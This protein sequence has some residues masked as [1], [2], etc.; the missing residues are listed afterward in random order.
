MS[1]INID[2]I[3]EDLK[4]TI[5]KEKPISHELET[6]FLEYAMSVIV[7]RALPD[8]KDGFKPVHR[9][10]LYAA[11]GLGMTSD[12]PYKKSARLVG[13]VIGKYHPHGDT[14]VYEAMVRLAQ[15]F[16]MRYPLIDGHGNF[17]SVDGDSP[18]AMRYTEARM[19]KLADTMLDDIDKDTV[20]FVD[21]YD[22]SEKEPV[23]LP[24]L[25]PNMLGNG[26]SGIAVGM[27][28]NIPPHN[29]NE[30]VAAIKLIANNHEVTIE[31][32]EQVLKGP[33]FPTAAEIIGV[34]G[35]HDYFHTGRGSI[36]IRAK[37]EY[38]THENGKSTI[39]FKEI[40]YMVNKAD[41][42]SRIVDLVKNEHIEG[43][44]DLKDESSR[45]GIR[46]VIETK[47]DVVPEVLMNQLYKNT[48]LQVNFSV[49]MLA[50]VDGEPKLLNIKQALEVYLEHQIHVL[51]RKTRFDLKKAQEREHILQ[52][53]HIATNNI[54]AIIKIIR[55][56]DDTPTAQNILMQQF[57]LSEIQSKAI[58]DMRLKTLSSIER[59]RIEEELKQLA[60]KITELNNILGDEHKQTDIVVN[61]L[62]QLAKSFGDERKTTIQAGICADIEDEDLIPVEDI[63]ITLS[64]KGY[65]KRLPIDTYRVQR[66][67]G[68]GVIGLQ[69]NKDDDVDQ[70]I[71]ASTH[72]DILMLTDYGKVYR[73]RG[74]KIPIGSRQSKGIPAI[75]IINIA[76]DEHVLSILPIDK[77]DEGCLFFTTKKGIVKK[78]KLSE[79]ERINNNGKIAICLKEGDRLFK[80]LKLNEQEEIYIG[81][82][83]GKLVRFN[84]CQIRPMGRTAAGVRGIRLNEKDEVIGVSTS[85]CGNLILSIG[86]KGVGKLTPVDQYRLTKRN[87]GGVTTLKI[88]PKT[89]KLVYI[90]AVN[91]NEDALMI[92]SRCKIIRFSL[93]E[94]NQIGRSTSGVKLMDV[95]EGEKIQSVSI[96]T[97]KENDEA[98][99]QQDSSEPAIDD[100]TINN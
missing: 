28:T 81:A 89:G 34:G 10:I 37:G 74:H 5:V 58:L 15:D 57:N 53:L 82:S 75:N 43:I 56:A 32:I 47:K 38:I 36:T 1:Q 64:S 73:V 29:L 14:A 87:A 69:T 88:T 95:D 71:T 68:V 48:S 62:D 65:L 93:S 92:T 59:T 85:G 66:R 20:D 16:S 78:T 40:P 86:T 67:G 42:I 60:A 25:F 17:G 6:S 46:I 100:Q 97:H 22:G 55:E 79:F 9:R 96:F 33:D 3:R 98:N 26:T 39:I 99:D 76:K 7:S 45:E 77:Y 31:E 4:K 63:V 18:A 54:D 90:G 83:N 19:S 13:E 61:N 35:I 72:T 80:V 49:N 24:A 23:I 44:A 94:L 50:L 30:L 11:Y 27:A 70:L 12:K 21:N 84:S 41:L 8:A 52:G 91:G 51:I 2:K